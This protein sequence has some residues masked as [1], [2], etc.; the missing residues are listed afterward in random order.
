MRYVSS[1]D[2]LG[3]AFAAI[4]ELEP[5]E[6]EVIGVLRRVRH[7]RSRV[8]RTSRLII[9][10]AVLALGCGGVA[11]A[12]TML[13]AAT[14]IYVRAG[15]WNAK[16]IGT[17][18]VIALGAPDDVS[19]GVKLTRDIPFA[20][21]YQSWRASEIAFQTRLSGGPPAGHA[22]VTSSVLRFTVA[23]AAV[24]SWLKYYVASRA[25]GD[26][27][28]AKSAGARIEAAPT[29]PAITGYNYPS[30]LGSVAAAVGARDAK[31][32]QA[33]ID[34]GDAGNCESFGPFPPPGF[35]GANER[36]K[37]V[38]ASRLGQQEIATDPV[39]RRL[40]ISDTP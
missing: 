32:V 24:C 28:A 15:G 16:A 40:G 21:G 31:L 2:P 9:V 35:H 30:G 26:T 37:I 11:A 33:L 3:G 4:R 22:F 17:G 25:D 7:R 6:A 5:T 8:P 39:A 23:E 27:S 10:V 1:D 20:P 14:G 34:A 36:A 13:S 12:V 19:F 18:E 38:A 29:W